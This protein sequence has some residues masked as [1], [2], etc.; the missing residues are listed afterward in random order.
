MAENA[1]PHG[2]ARQL[3][4]PAVPVQVQCE[5]YRCLAYRDKNGTWINYHNGQPLKG[6]VKLVEY[7]FD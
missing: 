3:P 6:T 4:P 7:T 5:G 2:K 1:K